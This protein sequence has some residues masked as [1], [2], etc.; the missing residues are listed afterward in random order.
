MPK[1]PQRPEEALLARQTGRE[2]VSK[3]GQT[4]DGRRRIPLGQGFEQGGGEIQKIGR[5]EFLVVGGQA[6]GGRQIAGSILLVLLL[7]PG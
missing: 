7:L 2:A 5:G 3:P 1:P 4:D 6:S